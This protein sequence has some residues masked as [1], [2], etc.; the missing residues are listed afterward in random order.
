MPK[1]VTKKKKK[2]GSKKFFQS[3]VLQSTLNAKTRDKKEKENQILKVLS[4]QGCAKCLYCMKIAA[5]CECTEED[6]VTALIRLIVE[7]IFSHPFKIWI[8]FFSSARYFNVFHPL[9]I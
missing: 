5:M 1:P 9:D 3:R 6:K 8:H 2:I 4:I 7:F